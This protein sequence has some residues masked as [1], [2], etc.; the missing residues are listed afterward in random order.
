MLV[1]ECDQVHREVSYKLKS[2]INVLGRDIVP[3]I[4]DVDEPMLLCSIHKLARDLSLVTSEVDN[5][6]ISRVGH[7]HEACQTCVSHFSAWMSVNEVFGL[8]MRS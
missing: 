2:P 5:G 1:S 6:N 4:L 8:E 7:R 3:Q